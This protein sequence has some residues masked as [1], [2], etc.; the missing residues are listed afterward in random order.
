MKLEGPHSQESQGFC[1]TYCGFVYVKN[2]KYFP[3]VAT[4]LTN[5]QSKDR[6]ARLYEARLKIFYK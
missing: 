5:G 2:D 6:K 4:Q 1:I 3:I